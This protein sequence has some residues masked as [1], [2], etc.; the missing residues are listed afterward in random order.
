MAFVE[1]STL[2]QPNSVTFE[3]NATGI[4]RLVASIVALHYQDANGDYQRIDMSPTRINPGDW[5]RYPGFDGWLVQANGYLFGLG[6]DGWVYFGG[7]RGEHYVRFRLASGGYYDTAANQWHA[8][9]ATPTYS[10][11]NLTKNTVATTIEGVVYHTK[12]VAEWRNLFTT[13]G[14]GEVWLRF[15]VTGGRL[16]SE[17]VMNQAARAWITANRQPEVFGISPVNAQFGFRFEMDW[18]DIPVR[19][20]AGTVVGNEFD[21]SAGG[22]EL[23]NALD[24][25]LAFMPVDSIFVERADFP[26]RTALPQRKRF[27]G[28][29]LYMGAPATQ[30]GALPAGD[31]VFDPTITANV[32]A[33]ADDWAWI[34]STDFSASGG[35]VLGLALAGS[36]ALGFAATG[37]LTTGVQH[38]LEGNS[39]LAFGAVGC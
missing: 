25:L 19:K 15:V 38:A 21:D 12:T 9:A 2:R 33:G 34:T 3:D 17:Y 27:A 36:A 32:A 23:R 26:I 14:G 7:R 22:V 16:K 39:A 37:S 5:A 6:V 11:A 1:N 29:A 30:I 28:N 24:E 10:T 8:I 20:V 13:P 18:S 31:L 35:L 4:R